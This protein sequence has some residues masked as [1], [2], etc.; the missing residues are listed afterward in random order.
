MV[1]SSM[2]LFKEVSIFLSRCVDRIISTNWTVSVDGRAFYTI[3]LVPTFMSLYTFEK[4]Y[5]DMN[6]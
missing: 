2:S 6:L 1:S 4:V 5:K 3:K